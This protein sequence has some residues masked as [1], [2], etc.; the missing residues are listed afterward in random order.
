MQHFP[1]K[2][3]HFEPVHTV[4][5]SKRKLLHSTD[6][7]ILHTLFLV[8]PYHK[9]VLSITGRRKCNSGCVVVTC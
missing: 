7:N 6:E 9:R 8:C 5:L 3:W 2:Y 4:H 1:L